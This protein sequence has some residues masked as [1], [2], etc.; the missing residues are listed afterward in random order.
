M[1]IV[2]RLQL[3]QLTCLLTRVYSEQTPGSSHR[4]EATYD[5]DGDAS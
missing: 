5:R 1:F 3:K 4:V 2:R